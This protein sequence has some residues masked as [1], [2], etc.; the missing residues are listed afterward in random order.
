MAEVVLSFLAVAGVTWAVFAHCAYC[1]ERRETEDFAQANM[2][3]RGRIVELDEQLTQA[4][5][6]GDSLL[7]QREALK[8]GVRHMA[9]CEQ[10]ALY[11][12]RQWAQ[13]Y[14]R[15]DQL[16]DD[17]YLR[18]YQTCQILVADDLFA[19]A[20]RYDDAGRAK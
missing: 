8:Q 3:L 19:L 10:E 7:R 14:A 9:H 12:A 5:N 1:R 4:E 16:A 11:E 6:R 20:Q 13:L 15:A 2:D 18:G 17:A